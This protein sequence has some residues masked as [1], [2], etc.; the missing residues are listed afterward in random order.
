MVKLLRLG[1]FAPSARSTTAG[2]VLC[3]FSA[4]AVVW[5]WPLVSYLSTRIPHDPGDP[6]LNT[7]L[8]AWQR[9]HGA[10]QRPL[11]GSAVLLPDA[12]R[13]GAL[14]TPGRARGPE[15]ADPVARWQ[16]RAGLQHLP[17]RVVRAV[18]LVRLPAGRTAHRLEGCRALR[19]SRVRVRAV[20]CRPTCPSSGPD[21]PVAAAPVVRDARLPG[22]RPAAMAAAVGRRVADSGPLERLLPRVH[23]GPPCSLARLVPPLAL[24]SAARAHA[25]HRFGR[26]L[27]GVRADPREVQ[28]SPRGPRPQPRRPGDRQLQRQ[29]RIVSQPAA[30][31]RVLAGAL[32]SD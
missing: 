21:V 30:P 25:D 12:R 7:Y 14:R 8:L 15:L 13:A 32:R 2:A 16:P 17:A 11:V 31:A 19:R 18:R 10:V 22:G 6:V 3:L 23:A 24:A 20:S 5:T 4:L 1:P 29:A 26:H 27:A 9:D 28:G